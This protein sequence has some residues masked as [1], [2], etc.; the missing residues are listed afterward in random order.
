MTRI[1]NLTCEY[2]PN[3]LGLDITA[4]RFSWQM[5]SD[6]NGARQTAYAICKGA[7]WHLRPPLHRRCE[8]C[9]M[10]RMLCHAAA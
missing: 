4:P 2:S 5:T 1:V 3:P 10:M 9:T 8:R 6:R 7:P